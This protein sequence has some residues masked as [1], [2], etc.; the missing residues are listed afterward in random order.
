MDRVELSWDDV[1]AWRARRHRLHERAP[2]EAML[3]VVDELCGVHAQVM[4]SAEL[5]LWARVA[6]LEPDAV[7]TALWQDRTLV[8]TWAM[9]GT[10]H[11]LPA[12]DYGFWQAALS[13]QYERFTKPSWSKAF[14][15]QP[16]ELEELIEE[17]RLALDGDPLTREELAEAAA[18]HSANP[19]LA[20]MLSDNWGSS[21]KPAAVRGALVF[22]PGDGQK[23]RFTRPDAW[24]GERDRARGTDPEEAAADV[25]RRYLAVHGPATREDLAR[26]WGVQPAPAG[27]LVKTL[28]DDGGRGRRRGRADV[29]A[30]GRRP[31]GRGGAALPQRP[32]AP[33]L[34]PVR[35]R[36]HPPRG[37]PDAARRPQGPGV[38]QPGVDLRGPV[39]RRTPSRGMAIR[40]K[41]RAGSGCGSSRFRA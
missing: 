21:L 7:A 40:A 35:D 14:G 4:S 20:H 32:P 41:G 2:A 28:G 12:S 5:T 39:R 3:D 19:R 33:G 22:G 13:T 15:I 27:R 6:D 9:R 23:V 11:L 24:L 1:A 38:P 16:D 18:R 25:A 37:A 8:K 17:V 31:R 26:W 29:H 10:L 36:R 30:G 34:R